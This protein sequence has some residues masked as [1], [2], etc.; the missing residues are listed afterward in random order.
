MLHLIFDLL[1]Y[2]KNICQYKKINVKSLLESTLKHGALAL[3]S[4]TNASPCHLGLYKPYIHLNILRNS[5]RNMQHFGRSLVTRLTFVPSQ[6][7]IGS[8]ADALDLDLDPTTRPTPYHWTNLLLL[9]QGC[10]STPIFFVLFKNHVHDKIVNNYTCG[11]G[12]SD[13]IHFAR[14]NYVTV[15][16][17]FP[18]KVH[19][20][21]VMVITHTMSM[22]VVCS[23]QVEFAVIW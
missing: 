6:V 4:L 18:P 13:V 16:I 23:L 15:V 1:W 3:V 19:K 21:I 8:W 14:S 20:D 9:H 2:G 7:P 5:P 17:N 10:S 22:I 12:V 11:W